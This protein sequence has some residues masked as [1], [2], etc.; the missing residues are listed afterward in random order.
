MNVD[1]RSPDIVL[2]WAALK[3]FMKSSRDTL[4][5]RI[6]LQGFPKPR[7]VRNG[8]T[9]NCIWLKTEIEEWKGTTK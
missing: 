9:I 6:K 2:G 3:D 8:R 5:R 4:D 1:P 7:R